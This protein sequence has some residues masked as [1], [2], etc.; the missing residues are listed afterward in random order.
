MY[1]IHRAYDMRLERSQNPS[2]YTI[3]CVLIDRAN[4]YV[5]HTYVTTVH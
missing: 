5:I 4:Y 1:N 3:H 2:Y